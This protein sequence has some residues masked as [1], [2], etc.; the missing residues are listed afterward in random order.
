[1]PASPPPPPEAGLNGEVSGGA[2]E[3]LRG[4]ERLIGF[5]DHLSIKEEAGGDGKP[6]VEQ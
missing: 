6:Q 2:G 3:R 1:M 5:A 4:E